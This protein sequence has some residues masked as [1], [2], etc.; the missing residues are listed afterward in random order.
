MK[1]WEGKGLLMLT[2]MRHELP[3]GSDRLY[4]GYEYANNLSVEEIL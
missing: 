4:E 1:I 2:R 3:G